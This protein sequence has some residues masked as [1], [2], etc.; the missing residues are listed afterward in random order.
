[1]A[2][3]YVD[4][5]TVV[6]QKIYWA[7]APVDTDSAPTVKIYDVTEDPAIVPAISPQTILLSIT[8]TNLDT[9][10]GNYQIVLPF[11]LTSR[12]RKLKLVWEYTVSSTALS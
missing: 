7:G 3:A 1:M 2:E 11:S 9:D 6:R 5:S 12:N 10:N 4:S 8:A